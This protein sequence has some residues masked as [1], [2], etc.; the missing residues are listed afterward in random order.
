VWGTK[1][2]IKISEVIAQKTQPNFPKIEDWVSETAQVDPAF[3]NQDWLTLKHT[4]WNYAGLIKTDARLERA[5]GILVEL[6]KGIDVFYRKAELSDSLIGL[7]HAS[8]AA[9]LILQACHRNRESLGCYL[10]EKREI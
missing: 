10:R 6:A 4:M 3:L 5:E 7:R 9:L 1:S 2:G 8:T